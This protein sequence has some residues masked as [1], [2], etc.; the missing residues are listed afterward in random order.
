M[1]RSS[2]KPNEARPCLE[3]RKGWKEKDIAAD[4]LQG[5]KIGKI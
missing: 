5:V 1:K 2:V 4:A 3:E